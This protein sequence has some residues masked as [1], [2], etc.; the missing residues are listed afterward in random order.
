MEYPEGF[1]E[2]VKMAS[3]IK[4]VPANGENIWVKFC[5]ILLMGKDRSEPDMAFVRVLLKDFLDYEFVKKA[6]EFGWH[7]KVEEFLKQRKEKIRDEESR[8]IIT[9]IIRDLPFIASSIKAGSRFFEEKKIIP[10]IDNLTKT[11]EKTES[12]IKEL[13]EQPGFGY[14]KSI[15][16]LHSIGRGG[17]FAPP[18]KHLKSFLNSDVGPYYQ[19][20]ED[21]EYFMKQAQ[22]MAKD[23]KGRNLLHI[24][25]AIYFFRTFKSVM[26]RGSKFTPKKLMAFLKKKKLSLEKVQEMLG[27]WDTR[28]RILEEACESR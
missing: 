2:L 14:S 5:D 16:W 25:K 18:T 13:I 1:P 22:E 26:P 7:D 15:M 9:G 3:K 24:Y 23:F 8:E 20:Y 28:N 11:R 27:D 10:D 17:D 12:L 4:S 21:D 19:Y 6:T